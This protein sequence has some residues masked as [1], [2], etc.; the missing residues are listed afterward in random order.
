[1]RNGAMPHG[2]SDRAHPDSTIALALA[3]SLVWGGAQ[4]FRSSSRQ[5][6]RVGRDPARRILGK[7]PSR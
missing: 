3:N 1:M 2:P 7:Q 5:L 4:G 6:N